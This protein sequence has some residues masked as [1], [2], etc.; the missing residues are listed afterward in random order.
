MFWGVHAALIA[1]SVGSACAGSINDIEHVV[2]FMQENRAFD[3]RIFCRFSNARYPTYE[4]ARLLV[5]PP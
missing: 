3:V 1:L 4:K 5:H 2:V